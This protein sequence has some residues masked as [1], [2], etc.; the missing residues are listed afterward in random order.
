MEL[1]FTLLELG[2]VLEKVG[3]L[4]E[5]HSVLQQSLAP[6]NELGHRHYIT[7]THRLLGIIDLRGCVTRQRRREFILTIQ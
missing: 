2:E 4:P 6:Y 5:A 1:A 3:N 7:D